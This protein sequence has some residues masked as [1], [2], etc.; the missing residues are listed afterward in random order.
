MVK[1]SLGQRPAFDLWSEAMNKDLTRDRPGRFMLDKK[2]SAALTHSER[3][4][5][6]PSMTTAPAIRGIIC[7]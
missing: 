6:D 7:I 5:K 4:G 1:T 2:E 3:Q